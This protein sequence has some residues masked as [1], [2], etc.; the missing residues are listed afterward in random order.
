MKAL[1]PT[2]SQIFFAL[3]DGLQQGEAH[4]IETS[5]GTY[6]PVL[7]DCLSR[8]PPLY[9]IA[10]R[11]EM[12]GDLVPDPDVQFLVSKDQSGGPPA[13]YPYAI[14]QLIG[15]RELARF[16]AHGHV[17]H[18]DRR[19]QASL[20]DFANGWM[21]NIR[22]QQRRW[23]EERE[24]TAAASP[25]TGTLAAGAI[26]SATWGY[27]QTNVSFYIVLRATD[28][29]A[30]VQEIGRQTV[31]RKE[32]PMTGLALPAPDQPVGEPFRRKIAINSRGIVYLAITN[33]IFAYPWDG[34]P[35]SWT[36]YA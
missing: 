17:T 4:K 32:H 8:E 36:S 24:A 21:R 6:M 26:L 7:V 16:D 33:Y 27:D 25:P 14:D 23:F 10:H 3:V 1:N 34:T 20:A 28:R 2:A 9:A 15:S 29:F 11:F 13:P 12:N 30:T 35:V 31:E 5:G 19:G 22:D 18:L